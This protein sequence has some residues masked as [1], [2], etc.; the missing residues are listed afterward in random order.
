MSG[1][2]SW[3]KKPSR[4]LDLHLSRLYNIGEAGSASAR[5]LSLCLMSDIR[6][7]AHVMSWPVSLIRLTDSAATL[8]KYCGRCGSANALLNAGLT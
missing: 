2:W 3:K 8:W 6:L 5:T 1:V 7:L 4:Q